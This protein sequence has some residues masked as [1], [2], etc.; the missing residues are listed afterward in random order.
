MIE[1]PK[2]TPNSFKCHHGEKGFS[3]F[4]IKECPTKK[5]VT[6]YNYANTY[7][8]TTCYPLNN[9]ITSIAGIF[10]ASKNMTT[11][12][13]YVCEKSECNFKTFNFN[14]HFQLPSKE[15]KNERVFNIINIQNS[16]QINLKSNIEEDGSSDFFTVIAKLITNATKFKL[17]LQ[18]SYTATIFQLKFNLKKNYISLRFREKEFRRNIIIPPEK[19]IEIVFNRTEIYINQWHTF[20]YDIG[21]NV[22]RKL[23]YSGEWD[24]IHSYKTKKSKR[25]K[26]CIQKK[27]FDGLFTPF[28]FNC[29][30]SFG[31][32]NK[33]YHFLQPFEAGAYL[34]IRTNQNSTTFPTGIITLRLQET[35][36]ADSEISLYMLHSWENFNAATKFN[37]SQQLNNNLIQNYPKL[38]TWS[39]YKNQWSGGNV[40]SAGYLQYYNYGPTNYLFIIVQVLR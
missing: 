32:E 29:L 17:I 12:D 14:H 23:I 35:P 39:R 2:Y 5:C 1:I 37:D 33:I 20:N 4:V 6:I 34:Y 9:L 8:A 40:T 13:Y 3:E 19:Q 18:Y 27:Y 25:K 31:P 22:M 36:C 15:M 21:S 38:S 26:R 11:L 10:P 16:T 30:K 7:S 24:I 28:T